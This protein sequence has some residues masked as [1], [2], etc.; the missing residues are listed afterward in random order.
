MKR[1]VNGAQPSPPSTASSA[2][3]TSNTPTPDNVT[4]T[5]TPTVDNAPRLLG[6]NGTGQRKDYGNLNGTKAPTVVVSA[7][8]NKTDNKAA[9]NK[10]VA[11]VQSTKQTDAAE[12]AIKKVI[13]G[14]DEPEE[15]IDKTIENE[16]ITANLT[17]K[18]D[19]FQYYNGTTVVDKNKSDEY[20]SHKKEYTVSSILS[21]SHR[22]AIVSITNPLD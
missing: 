19:F 5:D 15:A 18:D 10:N 1:D 7:E 8:S 6:V 9:P 16:E 4:K 22:R 11:A 3:S 2:T 20:W 21:N 14:I 12:T 13:D 17:K